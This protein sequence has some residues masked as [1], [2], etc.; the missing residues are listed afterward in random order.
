MKTRTLLTRSRI[1]LAIAPVLLAAFLPA[2]AVAQAV[3]IATEFFTNT[4]AVFDADSDAI[5][6][7][8]S[9]TGPRD[10]VITSDL[11]YG[12]VLSHGSQSST[13]RVVVIDLTTT[14]PSRASGIR[15]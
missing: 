3:G 4:V 10:C 14:P 2:Q 6:G 7:H 12:F 8:I 5:I 11:E 1:R 9:V 15:R 13:S